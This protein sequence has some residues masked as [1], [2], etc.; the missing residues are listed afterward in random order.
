[1]RLDGDIDATLSRPAIANGAGAVASLVHIAPGCEQRVDAVRAALD[2]LPA[3]SGVSAWNGMLVVRLLAAGAAPLRDSV[4]AA[5]AI[6]RDGRAP[7]RVW[8]C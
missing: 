7:P 6:L 2:G 5:L 1:M 3:E 4:V 8:L